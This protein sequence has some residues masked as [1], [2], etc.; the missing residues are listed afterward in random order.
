MK[1]ISIS[2]GQWW[3][4]NVFF[5]LEHFLGRKTRDR[6][7][8]G[9]RDRL[10]SDILKSMKVVPL[11]EPVPVPEAPASMV[12][13]NPKELRSRLHA[14]LVFRGAAAD[15]PCSKKWD[16]NFFESEYGD[17]EVVMNDLVGTIDPNNPQTFRTIS[18]SEYIGMMRSGTLQYL[19]FSNLVQKEKKLQEDMDLDWLYRFHKPMATGKTFYM[20]AGG[21]GTVTPLHNEFPNVVYVQVSGR[22][23]WVLYMPEDRIFIDPR[24]DR[25]IYYYSEANPYRE[26]PER[27]P[28]QKFARR[29]EVILEPGDVLW[30][31]AFAWHYV[32]NLSVSIGVAYKYAHIGSAWRSS[33]MLT[34]LFFMATRPNPIV[35]FIA[36]RLKK[37]DYTLT[38][39]EKSYS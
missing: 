7:L 35:A 12:R 24:T 26:D 19:K 18:M 20:F 4:Y 27:F 16:L 3:R 8:A 34:A 1:P 14:P 2:A 39:S 29:Y 5:L 13:D 25:R 33:P 10:N 23:R 31:P 38:K 28:L 9:S 37:E 11:L 17:Y 21:P 6:I 32:E 15:W 36:S 22:K 30:F